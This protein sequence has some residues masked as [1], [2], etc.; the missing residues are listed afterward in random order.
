MFTIYFIR[1]L[2]GAPI[3]QRRSDAKDVIDAVREA[4][5]VIGNTAETVVLSEPGSGFVIKDGKG[6]YVGT[7]F[8][9]RQV[10]PLSPGFG[11]AL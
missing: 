5:H 1:N 4:E 8:Q 7:W 3:A 10:G 2:G 11:R 6:T 9:G